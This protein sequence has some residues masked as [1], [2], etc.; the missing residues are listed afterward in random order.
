[1]RWSW[2]LL[3]VCLP[4]MLAACG[5]DSDDTAS[6]AAEHLYEEFLAG[7]YGAAWDSLHPAQQ[8]I[9]ARDTFINCQAG[10]S[11][12][13][14]RVQILREHDEIWDAPEVGQVTTR[15]V[16]AQLMG[17]QDITQGTLHLV[18]VDGEWRWFLDESSVRAFKQGDC[19]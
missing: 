19:A 13:W 3:V 17:D 14:T 8:R 6:D 15:A 4:L 9:V 7:N 11:I 2:L 10:I 16:E 12:P 5:G 18:Q 1:M